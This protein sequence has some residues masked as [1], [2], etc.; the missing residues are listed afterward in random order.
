MKGPYNEVKSTIPMYKF[1]I[2]FQLAVLHCH[3]VYL[4]ESHLS[5]L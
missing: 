1:L 2:K 5:D 4:Y 3:F